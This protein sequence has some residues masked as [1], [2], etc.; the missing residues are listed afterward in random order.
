LE[1]AESGPRPTAHPKR[2]QEA[3]TTFPGSEVEE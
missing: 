1:E 3:L 2:V